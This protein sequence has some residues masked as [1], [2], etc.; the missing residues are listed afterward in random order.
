MITKKV[1]RQCVSLVC[2][3]RPADHVHFPME[4]I[5]YPAS[6]IIEWRAFPLHSLNQQI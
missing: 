6:T 3:S 1:G 4:I 5:I 2:G